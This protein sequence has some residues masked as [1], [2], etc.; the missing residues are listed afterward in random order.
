MEGNIIAGLAVGYLWG[1]ITV[2]TTHG[3]G[4]IFFGESH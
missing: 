3:I 2:P 4:R 1:P